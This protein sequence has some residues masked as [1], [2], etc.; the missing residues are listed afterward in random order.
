MQ[1]CFIDQEVD[2]IG[3]LCFSG[4]D[5]LTRT[6]LPFLEKRSS[7]ENHNTSGSSAPGLQWLK[8]DS[9]PT[10]WDTRRRVLCLLICTDSLPVT[11][12]AYIYY[13]FISPS[14][15]PKY[16]VCL[17]KILINQE[18]T[19]WFLTGYLMSRKLQGL[20]PS[21]ANWEL[22]QLQ[23]KKGLCAVALISAE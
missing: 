3:G 2:L 12:Y 10:V 14:K 20:D 15:E 13:I 9:S 16:T 19:R 23:Y 17:K 5:Q 1:F 4:C 18:L 7:Q 21:V 8:E 11:F 22:C 6:A